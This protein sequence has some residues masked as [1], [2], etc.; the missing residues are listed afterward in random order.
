[1]LEPKLSARMMESLNLG[2]QDKVLDIGTGSGYLSALMA[3][4]CAHITSVEIDP[5]LLA[6]A[7]RNLAM[8]AITNVTLETGDAHAGWGERGQFDAILISGS[9]PEI[10]DSWTSLLADG[11]RLIG[12][13]GNLPAMEV[14]RYS[15]AGD[16]ISRQSLFETVVPRLRNVEENTEFIF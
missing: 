5:Q 15:R 3:S 10:T 8:A 9:L 14:V 2:S 12:I 6:Q 4:V 16:R 13:E 11:G 7:Q 1:M